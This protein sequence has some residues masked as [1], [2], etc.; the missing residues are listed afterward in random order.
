MNF[1]ANNKSHSTCSANLSTSSILQTLL[2]PGLAHPQQT[3]QVCTISGMRSNT[4]CDTPT[5]SRNLFMAPTEA[6][7]HL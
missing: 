5:R 4:V 1:R 2:G 6:C 7:H 3:R